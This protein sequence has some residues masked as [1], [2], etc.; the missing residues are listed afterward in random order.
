MKNGLLRRRTGGV[1]G[2]ALLVLL[3][4]ASVGAQGAADTERVA[5]NKQAILAKVE[6]PAP[7]TRG[8]KPGQIRLKWEWYL[9]VVS[10]YRYEKQALVTQA[11]AGEKHDVRPQ[12]VFKDMKVTFGELFNLGPEHDDKLLP[13]IASGDLLAMMPASSIVGVAL[14]GK[15]GDPKG[16]CTRKLK[17]RGAYGAVDDQLEFRGKEGKLQAATMNA[18]LGWAFDAVT[19]RWKDIK[20]KVV[21]EVSEAKLLEDLKLERDALFPEGTATN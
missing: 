6:R 18:G 1:G 12:W 13:I 19:V 21:D 3:G 9:K 8:D 4:A 5:K 2:G 14:L 7:E 16:P 20:D 11:S 10:S 17:Q 15:N